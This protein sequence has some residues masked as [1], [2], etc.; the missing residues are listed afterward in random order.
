MKFSDDDLKNFSMRTQPQKSRDIRKIDQKT[1][2][3]YFKKNTEPT[4]NS[5]MKEYIIYN[6]PSR[7]LRTIRA[8][9]SEGVIDEIK[10]LERNGNIINVINLVDNFMIDDG[11]LSYLKD[12]VQNLT[13]LNVQNTRVTQDA[14]IEFKTQRQNVK[15]IY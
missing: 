11:I 5:G 13:F 12:N 6:E 1:D 2:V 15:V 9:N 3:I 8:L 10:Q 4:N 14:I 7:S